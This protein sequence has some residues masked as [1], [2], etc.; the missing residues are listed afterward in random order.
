M[1][2]GGRRL[3]EGGAGGCVILGTKKGRVYPEYPPNKN[4]LVL[5]F[6]VGIIARVVGV[7]NMGNYYLLPIFTK[8]VISAQAPT[9]VTGSFVGP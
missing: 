2:P 5:L 3:V 9:F 7:V 4:A 1:K 6:M 8:S